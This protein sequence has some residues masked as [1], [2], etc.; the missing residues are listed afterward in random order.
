MKTKEWSDDSP[1]RKPRGV[2]SRLVRLL[3]PGERRLV[4]F[5]LVVRLSLVALDLVG[6]SLIGV[7]VSLISGTNIGAGSLT[8]KAIAFLEGAGVVN[9]YAIF[10]LGSVVF[11]VAKGLLSLA[12][13]RGL[14]AAVARIEATKSTR[15]FTRVSKGT[16]DRLHGFGKNDLGIALVDSL[17]MSVSKLIMSLSVIFGESTLMIAVGVYLAI[18]NSTLLFA[19][20]GYFA[21]LGFLMQ[22]LVAKRTRDTAKKMQSAS[23]V[24]NS[25]IFDLFDNFRQLK[26]LGKSQLVVEK[27]A[28]ARK[29][30]AEG[31]STMSML[32][33]MPRYITEI[34]LMLAFSLLLV[35]RSIAPNL[36]DAATLAI[37]VAGSFRIMA[38]LLPFQGALALLKQ[39]SGSSEL[40]LNLMQEYPTDECSTGREV[41]SPTSNVVVEF[42]DVSY[43]FEGARRDAVKSCSIKLVAGD[44]LVVTG[45]SGSGKSTFADL[46]LGLRQPSDGVVLVNGESASTF[47]EAHPGA[48]G[49]V[50]QQCALFEGSIEFNVALEEVRDDV[51]RARVAYALQ[52]AGLTA[53]IEELDNGSQTL[54]GGSSRQLSGGQLQRIGIARVLY[55]QPKV[56]VLDESTSAL[57][58]QTEIEILDT[59]DRL[60]S[61]ITIIAIAHR[62]AVV[63]RATRAIHFSNGDFVE[64]MIG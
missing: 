3:E 43:R 37:F 49:Y 42:K 18:L 2:I 26:S 51:A 60:R 5:S 45:R 40:A 8:G 28:V 11:F 19:M 21:I 1:I 58:A 20:A 55:A 10:G 44:Y 59:L 62:G 52:A 35:Q 33:V 13:N 54:V 6:L 53:W 16:L 64:R 14:L 4:A 29:T 56:L 7:T 63:E 50:P 24:V 57:D 38:S 47:V 46:V 61:G 48:I 27:F 15:L 12:L 36:F 31:T 25:S 9:V 30:I 23:A 41:G 17:D 39:I 34:A 22:I 32:S